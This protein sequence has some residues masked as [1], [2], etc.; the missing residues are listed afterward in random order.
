MNKNIIFSTD[1]SCYYDN[2]DCKEAYKDF[3]EANEL[4]ESEMSFDEWVQEDINA[5]LEAERMNLDKECGDI[6]CIAELGLWDGKHSG[7]KILR[8]GNVRHIFR[9][10]CGDDVEFYCDR[11]NV[12]CTDT[13]HDGTNHYTFREIRE[14]VNIDKLCQKIY[15]GEEISAQLLN[16]YTKSLRPYVAKVYGW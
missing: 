7:Y 15:D 14:G 5:W 6:L 3:L 13:H 4:E 8:G 2:D 10:T 1:T 12:K 16:K 11:Y 9:V